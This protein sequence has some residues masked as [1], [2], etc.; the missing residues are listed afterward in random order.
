MDDEQQLVPAV[1][2]SY[3]LGGAQT[4]LLGSLWNHVYR[5]EVA[6]GQRYSFRLC[7]PAVQNRRSVEEE[8]LWLGW[9]AGRQQVRVPRPLRNQHHELDTEEAGART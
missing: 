8:L 3:R 4:Q 6:D 7:A 9:V 1:L 5:V 2:G